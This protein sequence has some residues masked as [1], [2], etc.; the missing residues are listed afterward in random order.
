MLWNYTDSK[1]KRKRKK[2][3]VI[4]IKMIPVVTFSYMFLI[5]EYDEIYRELYMWIHTYIQFRISSKTLFFSFRHE[6]L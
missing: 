6:I 3:K 2:N 5:N 4:M 1:L